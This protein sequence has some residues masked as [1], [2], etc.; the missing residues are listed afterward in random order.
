M[1]SL[2]ASITKINNLKYCGLLFFPP[3]HLFLSVQFRVFTRIATET[4]GIASFLLDHYIKKTWFC[5]QIPDHIKSGIFQYYLWLKICSKEKKKEKE[6]V[7]KSFISHNKNKHKNCCSP[8]CCFSFCLLETFFLVSLRWW[9]C[10]WRAPSTWSSPPVWCLTVCQGL[11]SPDQ[12]A[13]WCHC[14]S[15]CPACCSLISDQS[16][17]SASSVH[18]PTSWSG[19]RIKS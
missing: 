8:S 4:C 10:W 7:K 19:L 5:Y 2:K 1:E 15:C 14:S 6:K 17:F 9:S 16:L 12:Y 11:L 13:L 18:W 3:Q